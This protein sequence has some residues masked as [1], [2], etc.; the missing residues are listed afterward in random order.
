MGFHR[1]HLFLRHQAHRSHGLHLRLPCHPLRL[2]HHMHVCPCIL[3]PLQG[4]VWW[5]GAGGGIVSVGGAGVG[6]VGVG[7]GGVGVGGVGGGGVCDVGVGGGGVGGVGIGGG[8]VSSDVCSFR[9]G[10]T[11]TVAGVAHTPWS[12]STSSQH[13]TPS[14]QAPPKATQIGPTSSS[15]PSAL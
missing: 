12:Q 2:L 14:P 4:R 6:G 5:G 11:V 9:S 8:G 1:L 3:S 15:A 7:A 13:S 10:R